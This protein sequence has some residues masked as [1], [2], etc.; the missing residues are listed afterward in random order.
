MNKR[1]MFKKSVI[2]FRDKIEKHENVIE[3]AII[4]SLAGEDLYPYD[5]DIAIIL[6]NFDNISSIAK[7]ARQINGKIHVLEV[8]IFDTNRNY[9]GRICDRKECYSSSIECSMINCGKIQ[10][11]KVMKDFEF[12]PEDAFR[13]KIEVIFTRGSESI[14]IN[15]QKEILQL[16]GL[17]EPEIYRSLESEWIKCIECEEKFEFTPNEQKC[18]KKNRLYTPKRC[19]NC[20][21]RRYLDNVCL[22]NG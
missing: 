15:W 2:E 4:G 6:T 21:E 3:I 19:A 20:R 8:F 13:T 17:K 11:I 22:V 5:V 1:E 9:Y 7:S 12:K 16:L 14:F 18:Y 10:F